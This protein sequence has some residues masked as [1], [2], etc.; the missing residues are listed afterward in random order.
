M[1]KKTGHSIPDQPESWRWP[2]KQWRDIV[3]KIRAGKSLKPDI[4]PNGARV[5]VALSFDLIMKLKLFAGVTIRRVNLAKVSM[6]LG[7]VCL[8]FLICSR[9]TVHHPHFLYQQSLQCFIQM[10]KGV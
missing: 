4:W 7:L 10:N 2:E 8:A 9:T 3:N 6:A 1:V 5:A